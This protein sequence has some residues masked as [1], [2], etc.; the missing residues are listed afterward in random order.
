MI[1]QNF[2]FNRKIVSAAAPAPTP[3]VV[4]GSLLIYYDIANS[5]CYPGSGTTVTDL[6]GGDQ[7]M[8]LSNVTYSSSNGGLLLFNNGVTNSSGNINYATNDAAYTISYIVQYISVVDVAVV[9]G[10]YSGGGADTW[11]GLYTFEPMFSVN[12]NRLQSGFGN[13]GTTNF[14]MITVTNGATNGRKIWVN[15][16]LQNSTS[17]FGATSPGGNWVIG[18][19]GTA[20]GAGASIKLGAYLYYNAEL[21]QADV[22]QNYNALFTRY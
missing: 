10:K 5:S 19:F 11:S 12:G 7:N 13:P 9:V 16:T 18:Q 22:T 8:T 15:T 6:Q 2:G 21:S 1:F 14:Y 3:S 4:T 17:Y 20:G